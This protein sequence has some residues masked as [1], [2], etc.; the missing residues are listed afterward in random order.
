MAQVGE[1]AAV[2]KE[3]RGGQASGLG[4]LRGWRR[5]TK[6]ME[7]GTVFGVTGW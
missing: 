5:N 7:S 6:E 3:K 2:L 1:A 4:D